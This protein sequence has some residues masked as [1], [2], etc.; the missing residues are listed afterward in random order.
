MRTERIWI[1]PNNHNDQA[2]HRACRL[3][4][5]VFNV[6]NY[7]IRQAVIYENKVVTHS[8]VDKALTRSKH[9]AYQGMP[10]A[11]SAQRV[12]QVLGKD[13]KSFFASMK[14]WKKNPEKYKGRPKIPRYA[15]HQK[16]VMMLY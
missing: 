3:A 15:D 16:I 2:M 14:D 13:W 1:K 9:E 11:A 8:D 6:A 7:Q 4:K 5:C 10:S 12:I